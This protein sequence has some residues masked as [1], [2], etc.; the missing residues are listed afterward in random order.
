S[1][2]STSFQQVTV[3]TQNSR[4]ES[5]TLANTSSN[6][7]LFLKW[8]LTDVVT[9]F[10]QQNADQPLASIIS[11]ESPIMTAG[12]YDPNSLPSSVAPP[13]VQREV[14]QC[15]PQ[16]QRRTRPQRQKDSQ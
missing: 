2:S 12:P 7:Q 10:D 15:R 13:V 11:A 1:V 3:S 5:L 9:V 8:Q 14:L 6:S 16:L 4:Y